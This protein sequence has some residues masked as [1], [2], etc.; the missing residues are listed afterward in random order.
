MQ[1]TD[2]AET[3]SLVV[4]LRDDPIRESDEARPGVIVD[5]GED[6]GVVRS[7]VLRASIVVATS[8]AVESALPA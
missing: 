1:G 2:D 3:D 8:R 6:G 5:V 7:W 4:T